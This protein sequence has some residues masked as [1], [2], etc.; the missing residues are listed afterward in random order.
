M[1]GKGR[2]GVGGTEAEVIWRWM[3]MQACIHWW[4]AYLKRLK[5]AS[6]H[7]SYLESTRATATGTVVSSCRRPCIRWWRVRSVQMGATTIL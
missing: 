1:R 4:S 2:Q 5:T 6:M 3:E 7:A